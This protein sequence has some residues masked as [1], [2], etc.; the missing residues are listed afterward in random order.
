MLN[1]A[2][3]IVSILGGG[4][5]TGVVAIGRWTMDERAQRRT[6]KAAKARAPLVQKSLELRVA[7]QADEILQGTIDTLRENY[8]ELKKDYAELK[9]QFAQYRRET[10]ER[11]QR[12]LQ[13]HERQRTLDHEE[14][15]RLHQQINDQNATIDRLRFELQ[16]YRSAAG[17]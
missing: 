3:V 15:D 11:R 9:R 5:V 4:A 16:G 2:Q 10:E 14:L 1:L 6:E 17:S 7:A 13:E 8:D 12:D